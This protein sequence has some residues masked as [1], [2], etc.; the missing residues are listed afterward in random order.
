MDILYF[1]PDETDPAV[2]RRVYALEG[3]GFNV[4]SLS[5]R[6]NGR[7][8]SDF[9]AWWPNF[10]L[11]TTEDRRYGKRIF[12]LI[13][14]ALLLGRTRLDVEE[15]SVLLARN[16]DMALLALL[17]RKLRR[18][19][20]P[21]IYEVLDLPPL[22]TDT[23]WISRCLR[24]LERILLKRSQLLV[25]SSPEFLTSYFFH[26]QHY[27]GRNLTVE[28][29]LPYLVGGLDLLADSSTPRTTERHR[30]T[31][32]WAG[33]LKCRRSFEL[34]ISVATSLPEIVEVRLHGRFVGELNETDALRVVATIPNVK[35]IGEYKYPD[36]LSAVYAGADLNWCGDAVNKEGNSDWLLPNRL[37]EGGA[38]AVPAIIPAGTFAANAVEERG[39]GWAIPDGW[40]PEVLEHWLTTLTIRGVEMSKD[41]IRAQPRSA[42]VDSGADLAAA[43]DEIV[44][45]SS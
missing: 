31:I 19:R 22:L 18:L 13:R 12:S 17:Y 5:F 25:V 8:A 21:L 42:F 4:H 10:S 28:N 34:L 24:W 45:A 14:A 15:P 39:L 26:V 16:L 29:K 43:I 1:A 3:A 20:S 32:V 35:Y 27:R 30:W 36:D 2:R 44:H 38:F 33:A 6:R 41:R 9:H 11:G 37:Y 7:I 23:R 40:S